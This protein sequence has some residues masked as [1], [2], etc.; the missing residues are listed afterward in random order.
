MLLDKIFKWDYKKF[1]NA[2]F[3]TIIFVIGVNLFVVPANLYNGGILGIAQLIRSFLITVF[4]INFPFDIAGLIN[5]AF[6]IPLFIIAF[7][8]V[9][10]TFF[11][12][13][14]W[15]VLIQTIAF[16]LIP[17]PSAPIIE[18]MIT[19]TLV[20]GVIA[21][22]G[23]GVVLLS[24][25]SGGGTDIIGIV[26]SLRNKNLSVGKIGLAINI[27]VYGISGIFFGFEIMIYSIIYSIFCSLVVD[28]T[29]IQNICSSA[30]I[31]TKNKPNKL[32]DFIENELERGSTFW[33]GEGGYNKDKTYVVYVT[34]SKYELQRLERHLKDLDEHAF[35]VKNQNL[36]VVGNYPKYF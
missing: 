27:F 19:S 36:G 31:F 13:T 18:E 4:H 29:H 33:E 15:C 26:L 32:I 2:T 11:A 21:G 12:R 28:N 14:I 10:K 34:L 9:S 24:S 16:T 6:N 23:S 25:A 22:I 20:G 30:I 17:I 7:K 1:L 5:F 8:K 35:M 3:G